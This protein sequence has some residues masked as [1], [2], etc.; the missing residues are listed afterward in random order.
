MVTHNREERI[1]MM[2]EN[3]KTSSSLVADALLSNFE[4]PEIDE[5]AHLAPDKIEIGDFQNN[6][7]TSENNEEIDDV[8][9]EEYY[10]LRDL[11]L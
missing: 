6:P 5:M 3:L 7:V 8:I 10:R 9:P 2:I 11:E 1:K 4:T